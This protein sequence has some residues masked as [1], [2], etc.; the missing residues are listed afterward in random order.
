MQTSKCLLVLAATV[1]GM[2]VPCSTWATDPDTEIQAKAREAL[3]QKMESIG[4]LNEAFAE[5]PATSGADPAAVAKAR[6]ALRKKMMQID[7]DPSQAASTEAEARALREARRSSGGT[8]AFPPIEKP[9][10]PLSSDQQQKLAELLKRYQADELTPEEY[11]RE[12]A[13][14]IGAK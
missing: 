6:E 2:C 11:H 1:A 5:V 14:I 3:R 12:R 8:L 4:Q 9:A 13:K 10:S 7:S